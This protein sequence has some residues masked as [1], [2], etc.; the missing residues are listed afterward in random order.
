MTYQPETP[1]IIA[2]FAK[3]KANISRMQEL[4]DR[5]GCKLRPHIKT[6]KSTEIARM[7]VTAGAVGITCA[8]ISEGEVMAAGGLT[9]IFIAYPLIGESKLARAML[10][11]KRITRLILAADSL[12][13]A[14]AL[15]KAAVRFGI[16]IEV[17]LEIDT[18]ARRTGAALQEAA[19]LGMAVSKLANLRLTGLY[20]F[21]GMLHKSQPTTDYEQ[22]ALEECVLLNQVKDALSQRGVNITTLSAGSTPTGPAC[23]STGLVNEIRP[24][25]YV[26]YDQ[27]CLLQ[28]ICKPE[29]I[30]ARIFTTVVSAPS[31]NYAVIDGG[32]K[33][34][35]TDV[36]LC[37]PPFELHSYGYIAGRD[38]LRLD[39][40]NE[41][42]GMLRRFD[43]GPTGLKVG[44]ALEFI[45]AH[46]CPAINLQNHIFL[47]ENGGLRKL[48]IDARGM[49]V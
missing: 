31:P 19:A 43:G 30:A 4:C 40:L 14:E 17:R 35:P 41:E 37:K 49:V 23:A 15:S 27:M 25:T 33:T 16:E 45:P 11:A 3:V 8:K 47:N 32:S 26:F 42:H 10:L 44:D 21:K 1:C 20:T 2:D 5:Y 7:Q 46:I 48:N 24:G 6:H 39:R 29:D 22:A 36:T 28:G 34:F 38:D 13:G 12:E 18:G 9:D